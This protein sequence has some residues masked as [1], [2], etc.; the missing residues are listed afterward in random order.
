MKL[1][2]L[3]KLFP[4]WPAW[5]D[6]W[7]TFEF[8]REVDSGWTVTLALALIALVLFS[9]FVYRKDTRELGPWWK[10]WLWGLRLA[11][12]ATLAVIALMPQ[13]R[14]SQEFAESSRVLVLVDSSVSMSRQDR[15]G[16]LPTPGTTIPSRAEQVQTLFE[17]SGLLEQLRLNHDV[18]VW[19]F[20]TQVARQSVLPRESRRPEGQPAPT[21]PA[22]ESPAALAPPNWSEILRPR[23]A[24]TRLGEA[25]L[26]AV[27]E[28]NGDTLSGIVVISDGQNNAGVD[29]TT[30][31][32][33]A[34]TAKVR[35]I[36]V[37]VG[38]TRKPVALQ[39][40]EIQS[41]THVHL[42]DGFTLSAF[43][44]GQGLPRQ[45][46]TVEL[47]SRLE[48]DE[49]EF[50]VVQTREEL[51]PADG[52]PVSLSF[53][54][55]PSEPGRRI[56]RVRVR[57]TTVIPDLGNDPIQDEVAI[58]VVDRKSR[59]LLLAGGPMRDYQF[60]RNLLFRDKSISTD[61]LLQTG[62]VGISQESDN[63]LFEF[64]KTREEL[65][66]YDVIVA[67]DPDWR[68][69][70]GDDGQPLQH[71]AEWCYAQAG[72]LILVAGEVNTPRLATSTDQVREAQAKLLEMY[73][74]VLDVARI[75]EEEDFSQAWPVEFTREGLEA[76]FLQI[77]ENSA[78]SLAAW[79]EFP[80]IFRCFPT[81][82][83]K[84][85]ATVYARVA[86]GR[87]SEFPVLFASQ[88]YGAGRVLYVGSGELWRLR[89]V[90]ETYYERLWIKLLREVGQGRLLRGTNRGI[91]LL[92]KTQYPLG[93]T[94]PLRV[95]LLD[96]QFKDYE[97]DQV[98][99]ELIDP[100]GKP[101]NPPLTLQG[102]K[103]RPGQFTGSFIAGAPGTYKLE[104]AIPD[105][106]D[107]LT[108][109]VSVRLP[110]LEFEHPEQNEAG[111]RKLARNETGGLYLTLAN[112]AQELPQLLPDRSQV[113]VQ[114][115][116]PK[117]LWD[118][119]WV[120]YLLIGLLGAEW[121]TR[122]LLKLA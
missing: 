96:P 73:P 79:R 23:G 32:D 26:Q 19:T 119:E 107:K 24:E 17:K 35:V 64:P 55:I 70:A 37:G 98:S 76:G 14:R 45:P 38:S 80:G 18:S 112:V 113:R 56:F 48:R 8:G 63:L 118:R 22:G 93:S 30:V 97:A 28:Q 44:S 99:L 36:P 109:S 87:A 72:G 53:N 91:L 111:L 13:T 77:T 75:S 95:R 117:S 59:V 4:G 16:E 108:G 58:E 116:Q 100:A 6:F 90:E 5:V 1:N 31:S 101:R 21:P 110:N 120:M 11:T 50:T 67:F 82:S 27:R 66:N 88:F 94:V 49:G 12:I 104:L 121:L 115:D 43:V 71:L 7:T 85:A 2:W 65:F 34:V 83:V 122:K 92:E 25:L 20:D 57:P 47:L 42:N 60:V 69:I 78:T 54:Y 106:S 29:P 86:D 102:D 46:M 9:G 15:E 33:L 41:P 114:Y 68:K 61:V 74:V 89:A 3:S 40:A 62:V 84:G 10:V 103:A 39:V 51:L 81:N 52:A 105:S